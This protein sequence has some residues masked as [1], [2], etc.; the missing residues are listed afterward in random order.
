MKHALSRSDADCLA[1]GLGILKWPGAL[2]HHKRPQVPVD[3][4]E[5]GEGVADDEH[6]LLVA[7]VCARLIE[8]GGPAR[9][10]LAR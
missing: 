10:A 8:V 9:L 7:T 6:Q 1:I 2:R 5:R 3:D 4:L